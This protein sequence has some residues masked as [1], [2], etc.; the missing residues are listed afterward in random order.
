LFFIN[1][2]HEPGM[3]TCRKYHNKNPNV[4]FRMVYG[5]TTELMG[6]Y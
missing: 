4:F 6:S 3:N 2:G 5:I 1:L